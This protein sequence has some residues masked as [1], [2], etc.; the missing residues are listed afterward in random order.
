MF[1]SKGLFSKIECPYKDDCVLPKCLFAHQKASI[2][3]TAPAPPAPLSLPV[4][5]LSG[6]PTAEP[7]DAQRK[8]RKIFHEDAME[9]SSG[10]A[11]AEV[12][13]VVKNAGYILSEKRPISP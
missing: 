8:R 7:E 13:P 5:L 10:S 12:K 9:S 1:T 11:K 4:E 2:M 3:N 6:N